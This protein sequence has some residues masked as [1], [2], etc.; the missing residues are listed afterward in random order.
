[1]G[2]M[3]STS[4]VVPPFSVYLVHVLRS[5]LIVNLPRDTRS[6]INYSFPCSNSNLCW[7]ELLRSSK[8]WQTSSTR[9]W[10][11][12]FEQKNLLKVN[13][14]RQEEDDY[15]IGIASPN[16]YRQKLIHQG[17]G[18]IRGRSFFK[19]LFAGPKPVTPQE[20]SYAGYSN[21]KR[22]DLDH[23]NCSRFKQVSLFQ[24]KSL[25]KIPP[26]KRHLSRHSFLNPGG[27]SYPVGEA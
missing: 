13:G 11:P 12:P 10:Q 15:R 22:C 24:F 18:G 21:T 9:W 2:E 25:C 1:M 14:V 27:I 20:T 23:H 16:P 26:S 19:H 5:Q 7:I 8:P 4:S 6:E 3:E 17:D